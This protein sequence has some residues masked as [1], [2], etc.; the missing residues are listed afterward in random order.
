MNKEDILKNEYTEIADLAIRMINN[1]KEAE[2]LY[3]EVKRINS[4]QLIEDNL[5]N[6][7]FVMN[8]Q[9]ILNKVSITQVEDC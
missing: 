6:L 8:W 2:E 3:N 4:M 7:Q 9:D 5:F 1:A